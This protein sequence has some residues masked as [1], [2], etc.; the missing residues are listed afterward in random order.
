MAVAFST[1]SAACGDQEQALTTAP[2]S[3]A[4]AG[5]ASTTQLRAPST[6]QAANAQANPEVS[7][8]DAPATELGITDVTVG[9][10]KEVTAQDAANGTTVEVNYVGVGQQSK[11]VFDSSFTRGQSASFPLNGVISGWTQGLVGMKEGGRREIVIPGSL[12]YGANPPSSDIGPDETL[13]FIVD[14]IKVG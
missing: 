10:G 13:V 8:P 7:I 6:T 5:A 14:L 11:Q 4:A 12:A 2:P 1:V 9:T 3:D